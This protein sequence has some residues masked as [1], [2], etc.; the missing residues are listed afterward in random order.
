M[1][2]KEKSNKFSNSKPPRKIWKKWWFWTLIVVVLIGGVIAEPKTEEEPTVKKKPET[3][4]TEQ[5]E[6]LTKAAEL[7]TE[8]QEHIYNNAIIKDVMNGFR[9]EK[10]GEYSIIEIK[11]DQVT[12]EILTDW[13]FN[14]VEKNDFNWNMILYTDRENEGVY[15]IAGIVNKDVKFDIDEYGDYSL[16][17]C[18]KCITYIPSEGETLKEFY[19]AK[20]N[21][22]ILENISNDDFIEKIKSAIQGDVGEDESIIDVKCENEDLYIY[23]DFSK[24]DPNPFTFEDL[25]VS[26]TCSITDSILELKEYDSLWKNIIVDFG[27]IGHIKNDKSNIKYNEFGRYFDESNFK[28]EK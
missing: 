19:S 26:R 27:E 10:I 14:Y 22:D 11:S 23:V 1:S 28:I 15:A 7:T 2:K 3:E 9:S 6:E 20:G 17:D 18:S 12:E 13:Y 16:G 4:K 8:L 5:M 24:T 21:D 25:A